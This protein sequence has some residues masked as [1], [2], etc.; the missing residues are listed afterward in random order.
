MDFSVLKAS[1]WNTIK[2]FTSVG[3]AIESLLFSG[4]RPW[5]KVNGITNYEEIKVN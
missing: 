4:P 2:S 1:Y 3:E 5:A